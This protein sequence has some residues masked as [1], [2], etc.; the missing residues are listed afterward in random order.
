MRRRPDVDEPRFVSGYG[1]S[2]IV[3]SPKSTRLQPLLFPKFVSKLSRTLPGGAAEAGCPH[4]D[5]ATIQKPLQSNASAAVR[6]LCPVTLFVFLAGAAGAGI[7]A[8]HFFLRADNLLDRLRGA[9][10]GHTG[11]FQF[12][13]LAAHEGFFQFVG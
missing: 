7:I 5:F 8:P 13:P 12:A 9:S 6:S 4:V 1:F 2:H 11:L 3:S 10:N